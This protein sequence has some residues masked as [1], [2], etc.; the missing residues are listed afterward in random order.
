[1]TDDAFLKGAYQDR[2]DAEMRAY[3]DQ[4]ARQYDK[5]MEDRDYA[6]PQRC[7]EALASVLAPEGATVL[8]IGC[9]TGRSGVALKLAGY[10]TVDGCD[11]S[12]EML[13]L[14]HAT[15]AYHRV[16]QANLNEPPLDAADGQYDAATCVGVFSFGHV[17]PD[18]LDEILRIVKPG[19]PVVIGLNEMFYE[20]GDLIRKLESMQDT[21]KL[22]IL[23][24]E[25]GDHLPGEGM[26]GWVIRLRKSA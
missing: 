11:L 24:Q 19:G 14:A 21:G 25:K 5:D 18:A 4:W 23:S 10:N 13:A 22:E 6:Q 2:T 7:T 17:S 3:Y 15:H 8:D 12:D 26:S 16:F 20:K 9:G 1:M